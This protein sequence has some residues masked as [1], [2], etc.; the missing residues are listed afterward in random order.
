MTNF[1]LFIF[2]FKIFFNKDCVLSKISLV[3]LLI[4][5]FNLFL[6]KMIVI[7]WIYL[8]T[9]K[10]SR[11]LL[12]YFLIA[13]SR[14]KILS[15]FLFFNIFFI[16]LKKKILSG[17]KEFENKLVKFFIGAADTMTRILVIFYRLLTIII[18]NKFEKIIFYFD[19][20]IKYFL[21]S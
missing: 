20:I 5:I 8:S 11:F 18:L 12:L 3:I 14:K 1:L 19:K 10:K 17:F 7:L 16:D 9:S 13:F 2:F 6:I 21:C 15:Y 4:L